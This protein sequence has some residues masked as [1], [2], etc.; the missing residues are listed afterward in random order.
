[1]RFTLLSFAFVLLL[2]SCN[3]NIQMADAPF[4]LDSLMMYDYQGLEKLFG[5]EKLKDSLTRVDG[6]PV[7]YTLVMPGTKAAVRLQWV[8]TTRSSIDY[9]TISGT[10]S[11]WKTRDSVTLSTPM[12]ELEQI[13]GAPFYF[14]NST[15]TPQTMPDGSIGSG[16]PGYVM[17]WST[18]GDSKPKLAGHLA[19]VKLNASI[20]LP[21]DQD[22]SGIVSSN[23]PAARAANPIVIEVT[24]SRFNIPS[25]LWI[26]G[27]VFDRTVTVPHAMSN[28][29][30]K[31][32]D[33]INA[34]ILEY[35]DLKSFESDQATD[36]SWSNLNFETEMD[37]NTIAIHIQGSYMGPYPSEIDDVLF[38]DKGGYKMDATEI[39]FYTLFKHDGYF[40]FL[41]NFWSE[42]CYAAMNEAEQ[43]ADAKPSC[44]CY[45][46][47][48][49][50]VNNNYVLSVGGDCYPHAA[51]ACNPKA[52]AQVTLDEL[53]PYL[54][55][56]GI[57]ITEE[58][59][60][61]GKTA[62]EQFNIAN[63]YRYKYPNVMFI[64]FDIVN[65]EDASQADP[66]LLGLQLIPDD[67]PFSGKIE[68]WFKYINLDGDPVRISG[69]FNEDGIITLKDPNGY[70]D[71]NFSFQWVSKGEDEYDP[72]QGYELKGNGAA[73]RFEI[74]KVL[75][76]GFPFY[77]PRGD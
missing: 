17:M 39:P 45:D 59:G 40:T 56:F 72:S 63:E 11:S 6:K 14:Y 19:E 29:P 57:K 24:I 5:A 23:S 70:L 33:D 69:Q 13:N 71:G 52:S 42:K 47:T 34:V 55:D 9:A 15:Y 54:S 41:N 60:Y 61:Y 21:P 25:R 76:S 46:P 64:A 75:F 3:V 32:V 74:I 50:I 18:D 35:F 73:T 36:F 28:R 38:I 31:R 66:A 53:M 37:E 26:E 8:D 30:D 67:D 58:H 48:V 4:T 43:C 12:V 20:N 22:R 51:E 65:A 44:S 77:E 16:E 1:M 27:I 62:L 2:T 68:G 49:K 7:R 10:S